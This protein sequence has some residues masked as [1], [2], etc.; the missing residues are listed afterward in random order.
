MGQRIVRGQVASGETLGN[1]DAL[2]RE[3]GV[4]RTVLREA[5]KVLAAKGLVEPRP[6]TGTRVLPRSHWELIDPDVLHW[7]F[8]AAVN[9]NLLREISEIRAVIEPAAAGMAAERRTEEDLRDLRRLLQAM[10]DSVGVPA[11]YIT[12][13][14]R[15]HSAVLLASHNELL[16]RMAGTIHEAMLASRRVTVRVPGGPAKASP[17]HAA[18]LDAIAGRDGPA[19]IDTMSRLVTATWH[20]VE[21][22]LHASTEDFSASPDGPIEH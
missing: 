9:E 21:T 20:D 15:F 3:L 11:S 2:S 8:A 22:I 5:V 18:V 7:Q 10:S 12:A 4:S 17:L 6:K 13:D 14:L 1:E 19:A 16:A